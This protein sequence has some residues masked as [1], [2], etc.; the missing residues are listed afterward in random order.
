[1]FQHT[2]GDH[3]GFPEGKHGQ[4]KLEAHACFEMTPGAGNVRSGDIPFLKRAQFVQEH[5]GAVIDAVAAQC[6]N[7]HT[8]AFEHDA[9]NA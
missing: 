8:I 3:S 2:V 7:Q 6:K 4:A 5:R 9:A 1:M